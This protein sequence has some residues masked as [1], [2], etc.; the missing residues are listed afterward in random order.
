VAGYRSILP[1]DPIGWEP[2]VPARV[3]LRLGSDRPGLLARHVRCPVLVCVCDHD[4]I[5]PPRPAARVA[6]Q[7]PHGELRRYPIGHFDLFTGRWLEQVMHD[8][9]TFLRRVLLDLGS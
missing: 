6:E 8:Q 3:V 5:S 7:A 1:A 2:A 9:V 4:R